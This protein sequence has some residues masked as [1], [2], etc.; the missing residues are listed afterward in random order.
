MSEL[1]LQPAVQQPSAEAMTV[2]NTASHGIIPTRV[3]LDAVEAVA[4]YAQDCKWFT[5]LGGLPGIVVIFLYARELGI[6][7]LSAIMD[8]FYVVH[9]RVEMSSR[10]MNRLIIQAGHRIDFPRLDSEVCTLVGTRR[11]TGVQLEVTYT[12]E[13]ARRAKLVKSGGAWETSPEDMLFARAI[14]KLG[15]RLFPDII[16][17]A[18]AQGEVQ[19][20]MGD[21]GAVDVSPAPQA[22]ARKRGRPPAAQKVLLPEQP[23]VD[24]QAEPTEDPEVGPDPEQPAEDAQPEEPET[25]PVTEM[26]QKIDRFFT[27][28]AQHKG[29]TDKGRVLAEKMFCDQFGV[30]HYSLIPIE[31]LPE[32]N[33]YASGA[34]MDALREAGEVAP[35]KGPVQ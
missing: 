30:K 7:P 9:G 23:A 24:V 17:S 10:L 32:L 2:V 34:V 13:N 5:S 15:R 16:G 25:Y 14:S 35:E 12:I 21:F 1:F 18:Y 29:L 3:E 27:Y 33:K 19:E 6:Q 8:G 22:A 11:D 4:K 20:A 28:M 26:S 31:K